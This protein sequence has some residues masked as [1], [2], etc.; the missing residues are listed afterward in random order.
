MLAGNLKLELI[1]YSRQL[2]GGGDGEDGVDCDGG[3]GAGGSESTPS[4]QP[5]KRCFQ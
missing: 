3:D 4:Y 1:E 2:N 5:R